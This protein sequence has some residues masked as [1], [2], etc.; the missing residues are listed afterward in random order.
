[1]FQSMAQIKQNSAG[2]NKQKICSP[3]RS[4]QRERGIHLHLCKIQQGWNTMKQ[5]TK[6]HS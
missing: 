2:T 6:S 3:N 4:Y 1:M 5:H